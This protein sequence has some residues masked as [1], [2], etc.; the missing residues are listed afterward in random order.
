M[1]H[2]IKLLHLWLEE[3][4][5]AGA[6]NPQQAVLCTT[7]RQS[8]PQGRVV[9]IREITDQSLLFFTQ[10]PTKKVIALSENPFACIVFW[11]ELFQREV[12]LKGPI[13]AL[14]VEE[15][16]NYW[17]TYSPSAQIRFHSYAPTS[18]QP[19]AS[20]ALLEE[21]RRKLAQQYGETTIP[22]SPFYCGFRLIFNHFVF[23][24]YR[25]DELSDVIS[26]QKLHN[27]WQK[28]FLSP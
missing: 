1:S 23:Y 4:H 12:I 18:G 13:E 9:A 26:Y 28:V 16:Q 27:T 10:K 15:N 2:P 7:D 24:T 3:E 6:P 21:K 8:S 14:S 5:H 11:F 22:M 25:T 17:Q 20:K 19:I